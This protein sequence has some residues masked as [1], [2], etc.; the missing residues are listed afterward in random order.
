MNGL[1]YIHKVINRCITEILHL[2]FFITYPPA[3]S[4]SSEVIMHAVVVS[5]AIILAFFMPFLYK[6][7]FRDDPA[8]LCS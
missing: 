8:G 7:I 6:R 5:I 3:K 4:L 1:S 2:C